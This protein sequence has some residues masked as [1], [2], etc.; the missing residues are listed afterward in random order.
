MIE[1]LNLAE[2]QITAVKMSRPVT[3]GLVED[4]T[5]GDDCNVSLGRQSR[6][7]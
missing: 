2:V 7:I 3:M 1:G 5:I 4:I 6:K